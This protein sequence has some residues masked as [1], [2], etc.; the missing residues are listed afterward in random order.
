MFVLVKLACIAVFN[1]GAKCSVIRKAIANGFSDSR[2][3]IV[4]YLHGLGTVSAISTTIL[5]AN[6]V[7][8][9]VNV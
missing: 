8:N 4:K 9:D 7:I 5:T 6:C 2:K 1:S 3:Q